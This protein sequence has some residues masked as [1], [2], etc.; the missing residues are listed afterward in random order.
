MP[1]GTSAFEIYQR[2]EQARFYWEFYKSTLLINWVFSVAISVL[3]YPLF[4]FVLPISIMTGGPIISIFYKEVS[5]KH[6]YYF[7]YNR[8]ITKVHL[9]VT[10]FLL[11]ALTG[12]ILLTVIGYV[13]HF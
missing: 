13:K 11:N 4:L 9:L 10:T 12:L 7:Y 1:N 6:E 5:R 3:V 8:G 2:M